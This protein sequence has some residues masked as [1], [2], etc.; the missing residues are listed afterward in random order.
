MALV[1]LDLIDANSPDIIQ[2]HMLTAPLD[3]HLDRA[4]HILPA[5][6]KQLSD[7]FP[8]HPLRPPGQEPSIGSGESMFAFRPWKLFHFHATA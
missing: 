5:R 3:G 6:V 1:P 2:I 8:A 4:E 7:L